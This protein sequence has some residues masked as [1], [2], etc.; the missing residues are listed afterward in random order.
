MT[1]EIISPSEIMFSG[2]VDAV[3]LPG[4]A[5]KFT[6]LK[7]H[8]SLISVLK[9]DEVKYTNGGL[10]TRIDIKGGLADI[11]MNKISVCVY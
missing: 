8:A 3:T 11:D 5:G 2:E 1:L 9:P 6:V 7:N 4:V 10:E